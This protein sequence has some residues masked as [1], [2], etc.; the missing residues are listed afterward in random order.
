M[1]KLSATFSPAPEMESK[2]IKRAVGEN[3]ELNP[4]NAKL[5]RALIKSYIVVFRAGLK[6][7]E[8]IRMG[9]P[10]LCEKYSSW[11]WRLGNPQFNTKE[12]P[13]FL[14]RDNPCS[15][16]RRAASN[17]R[18]YSDALNSDFIEAL[19]AMKG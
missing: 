14:W 17:G 2:G 12:R 3:L 8:L 13:L 11:E 4:K 5:K 15:T 6:R 10:T 19:T 16:S 18:V 7:N 1:T 9:S